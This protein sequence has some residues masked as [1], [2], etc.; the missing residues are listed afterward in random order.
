MLVGNTRGP[1]ATM[2][3]K[4]KNQRN[5]DGSLPPAL[6]MES[7]Y[8]SLDNQFRA[9]GKKTMKLSKDKSMDT[10]IVDIDDFQSEE[11][12]RAHQRKPLSRNRNKTIGK[13]LSHNHSASNL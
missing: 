5:K 10:P 13:Q 4:K 2:K 9:D 11:Q 12:E 6:N 8:S 3:Y 7:I 1:A